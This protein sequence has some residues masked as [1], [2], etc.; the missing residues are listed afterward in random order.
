MI[1]ANA[2]PSTTWSSFQRDAKR[3]ADQAAESDVLLERR[4]GPDLVIGTAER[5]EEL[6]ESIDVLARLLSAVIGDAAVLRRLSDP[7]VL[8]WL[9]F[10]P[11]RDRETFAAEFVSTTAAA[12]D[13][14]T[15]APV[16][17]L[18][19]EWKN[20]AL[21]HADPRLAAAMRRDHPG[22]G[23]IVARPTD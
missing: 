8:P 22:A 9:A 15:L 13:L 12:I 19:H 5:R 17:V 6:V 1:A 23:A 21:V 18:L 20:T 7:S 11:K 16:S 3:V 10:L 14:G 2:I 4:D